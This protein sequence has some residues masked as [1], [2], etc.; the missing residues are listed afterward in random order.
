MRRVCVRGDFGCVGL[1]AAA[2]PNPRASTSR[3]FPKRSD[4]FQ[5]QNRTA[6]FH[7]ARSNSIV[8]RA[9]KGPA[10]HEV[11]RMGGVSWL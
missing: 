9:N 6:P 8:K 1:A 3:R 4:Y 2:W 5:R 11:R 10:D 7:F